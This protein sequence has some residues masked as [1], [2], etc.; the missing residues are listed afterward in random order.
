MPP[1]RLPILESTPLRSP[2]RQYSLDKIAC[3]DILVQAYRAERFPIT[4]VRPAHT[5]DRTYVVLAPIS[6]WTVIDRMRRG[7]PVVVPGDGNSVYVLTHATDFARGFVGLLG[8]PQ[9]IGECFHITTDEL[10]TW[11]AAA[12]ARAELVHISSETIARVEPAL[13]PELFD[14]TA[15]SMIYDNS[16]IKALVPDYRATVPFSAGAREIV[17]WYD[18]H[19]ERRVV[20]DRINA[21]LDKLTQLATSSGVTSA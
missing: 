12:G 20:D 19:S 3:E 15:H 2:D 9:A 11:T 8:N 5:Y 16:K 18:S 14:F 13:G 10:L 7:R 21:T 17:D 6:G 1:P 4:I